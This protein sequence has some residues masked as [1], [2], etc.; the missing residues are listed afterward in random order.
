MHGGASPSA[1]LS[2]ML[3]GSHA[4]LAAAAGHPTHSTWTLHAQP[5]TPPEAAP[6]WGPT[7]PPGAAPAP[8]DAVANCSSPLGWP[9]QPAAGQGGGHT[10]VITGVSPALKQAPAPAPGGT[11][12][13]AWGLPCPATGFPK[14]QGGLRELPSPARGF[15]E[16]HGGLREAGPLSLAPPRT[17]AAW[18]AA[19]P[20]VPLL[21]V[22]PV[23]LGSRPGLRAELGSRPGAL[24]VSD[25]AGN[26]SHSA[27][28]TLGAAAGALP[29]PRSEPCPPGKQ[30]LGL[31][32]PLLAVWVRAGQARASPLDSR[33]LGIGA[34]NPAAKD[35]AVH[36]QRWCPPMHP[37]MPLFFEVFYVCI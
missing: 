9:A 34:R 14:G 32:A 6:H 15:P 8:A 12:S 7:S 3:S 28:Q 1:S 2:A 21:P 23:R 18:G 37:Q 29:E 10:R 35:D 25:P 13:L 5:Q 30:S 36:A 31:G 11:L 27:G 24:P 19:G 16:G 4:P 26:S 17:A 33:G 22:A 20:A